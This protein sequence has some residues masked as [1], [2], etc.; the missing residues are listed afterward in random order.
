MN[1]PGGNMVSMKDETVFENVYHA[2]FAP[3]CY[4]SQQI[5]GSREEA[6]DLVENVFIKLW[7]TNKLFKATDN[8]AVF[9]YSCVKNAAIDLLRKNRTKDK[10]FEKVASLSSEITPDFLSQVITTEV[11]AEV[12][13]AIENL[14]SQCRKVITMSYLDG[15]SNQEI[16]EEL[17]LTDKTVRNTKVRALQTLKRNLPDHIWAILIAFPFIYK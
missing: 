2:Y 1:F 4:F 15:K 10:A 16:A 17:E 8:K 9:L 12:Y 6:E 3:L 11:W 5:L 7:E 13:R 14:P